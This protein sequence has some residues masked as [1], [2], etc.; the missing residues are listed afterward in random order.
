M[1]KRWC[2]LCLVSSQYTCLI[3]YN[4][5]YLSVY[6]FLLCIVALKSPREERKQ[7]AEGLMNS[8]KQHS[9][10][11]IEQ[12]LL[13][14]HELI[15]VAILWQEVWHESLEEASRQYFGEG[16]I[17]GMLDTLVPLHLMLQQGPMTHRE[18]SFMSA[19]GNELKD[20]WQV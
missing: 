17:Q 11:L 3:V 6:A 7:A 1:R 9:K 12:A 4:I 16:N 13:V 19:Y 15:R 20:A 2:I 5:T 8:L 14:S 10:V 18:T